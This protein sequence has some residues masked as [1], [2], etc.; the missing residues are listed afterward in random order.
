MRALVPLDVIAN[1]V[2]HSLG[3]TKFKHKF[4][5][6]RHL[7]DCYRD[8]TMYQ[9]FDLSIRTEILTYG[10]SIHLPKDFVYETKVGIVVNGCI[11]VLTLDRGMRHEKM[12]DTE[13]RDYIKQHTTTDFG[14]EYTFYNTYRNNS[15]LGEM[16]GR[17]RGVANRGTYDIDRKNGVI[18]L[19]SNIPRGCEIIIEY[20]SDGIADGLKLVPVEIKKM[21]EYYAKS[22]HY[23]DKNITQGQI[24]RNNYEREYGRVKRLYNFRD[25][26]YLADKINESFSPTNY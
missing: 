4:A 22:E 14:P 24:N 15:Y 26:L 25:A 10:N 16:Y 5:I 20:Q 3:D 6:V 19:G 8:F 17:G 11:A 21:M 9:D 18:H 7:L 13:C 2:C 23:A 1:D 12:N